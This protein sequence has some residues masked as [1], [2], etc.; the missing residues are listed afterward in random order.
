MHARVTALC[1]GLL[2]ASFSHAIIRRVDVPDAQYQALANNIPLGWIQYPSPSAVPTS[3]ALIA[4]QFILSAGHTYSSTPGAI[5]KLGGE[6]YN[7]VAWVKNPAFNIGDLTAGHDFSVARLDRRVLNQTPL[8]IRSATVPVQTTIKCFGMGTTGLGDGTGFVAPW[9]PIPSSWPPRGMTNRVDID[10]SIPNVILTDFDKPDGTTNTLSD[11]GSSPAATDLEGQLAGGD[12]GGPVTML[13]NGQEQIVGVNSAVAN[14]N[15]NGITGDYG[16]LS[17]VSK[18]SVDYTWV[19][20]NAWQAGRVAGKINLGDF[21]GSPMLRTATISLRNP[22]STTDLESFNVPLAI[23]SGFSFV[24]A[25]RGLT[26]LHITI[27]GF[28]ARNLTNVNIT[29]TSPGNLSILLPNGDPDQSQEVDA[30][31]IDLVIAHFG[32]PTTDATQGDLDGSGE[33]DATDIDI[34]IANFGILGQP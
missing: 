19:M 25:R 11:I 28:C 13:V 17:V 33:V 16:D 7:I 20:S 24:T 15:N 8:T 10:S 5:I 30:V 1:V 27:P 31:D 4:D 2:G 18:I 22:G 29:N 34:T 21:V 3:C 32:E 14:F 9:N 26:D 23:D 12:S 6:T